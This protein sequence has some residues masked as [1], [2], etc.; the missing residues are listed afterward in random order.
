M[1]ASASAYLISTRTHTA[2]YHTT[3]NYTRTRTTLH[4][5]AAMPRSA[6]TRGDV[7]VRKPV[8]GH[9]PIPAALLSLRSLAV[10][11]PNLHLHTK[12]ATNP[13]PA[14][15]NCPPGR[16]RP[17]C[18][19]LPIPKPT[20][21]AANI[22]CLGRR[23]PHAP[24]GQGPRGANAARRAAMSP[25]L[26]EGRARRL[27]H[28]TPPPN[29]PPPAQLATGAGQVTPRRPTARRRSRRSC[30]AAGLSFSRWAE[31]TLLMARCRCG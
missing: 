8:P 29:S 7:S 31:P 26:R 24:R 1:H 25:A 3:P 17:V 16:L 19:F 18:D 4:S 30:F 11:A 12:S 27:A 9:K 15:F 5:P 28:L 14:P 23:A 13:L 2:P 20:R 21:G 10:A 22:I 6:F